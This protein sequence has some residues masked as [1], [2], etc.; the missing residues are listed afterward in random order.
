MAARAGPALRG[1]CHGDSGTRTWQALHA[2]PR[3]RSAS[4]CGL[5]ELPRRCVGAVAVCPRFVAAA[6]AS[7]LMVPVFYKVLWTMSMASE[8]AIACAVVHCWYVMRYKGRFSSVGGQLL[9][10]RPLFNPSATTQTVGHKRYFPG[11]GRHLAVISPLKPTRPPSERAPSVT[12]RPARLTAGPERASRGHD[13]GHACAAQTPPAT[14]RPPVTTKVERLR[15]AVSCPARRRDRRLNKHQAH[16]R[17]AVLPMS[18]QIR[19][20]K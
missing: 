9:R 4:D 6:A 17:R 12:P 10:A 19:A 13:T 20:N 3:R 11:P 14:P 15:R 5:P 2:G 16:C 7:V 8:T 18:A 1:R